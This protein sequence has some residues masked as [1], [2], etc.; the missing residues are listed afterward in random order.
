[1]RSPIVLMLFLTLVYAALSYPRWAVAVISGVSL[2]AVLCL[3]LFGGSH[4][5]V[6]TN[7][8]Y[9]VGLMLTLAVTGVMGIYQRRTRPT[10]R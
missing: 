2:L 9:L 3:S 10:R 6:P 5:G 4:G 7:P 1:V 8:V